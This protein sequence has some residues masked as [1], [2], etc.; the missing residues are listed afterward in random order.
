MIQAL[1]QSIKFDEFVQW[2]P[3]TSECRY[4]L[5]REVIVEMPKPRGKHS[6]VSGNLA[7]DLGT[8]IRQ[9]NLLKSCYFIE[10]PRQIERIIAFFVNITG[11]NDSVNSITQGL[12]T[13]LRSKLV[14]NHQMITIYPFNFFN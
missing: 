2:L 10:F 4:E 7:Y 5:H 8:A 6:K 11:G 3:E 13:C 1:P 9:A 14:T 12:Q